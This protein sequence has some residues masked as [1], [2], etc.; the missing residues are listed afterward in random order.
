MK[1]R[2][3]LAPGDQLWHTDD[4]MPMLIELAVYCVIPLPF[5]KGIRVPFY[6]SI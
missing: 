6:N 5:T 3:A 1:A 2:K 4:W